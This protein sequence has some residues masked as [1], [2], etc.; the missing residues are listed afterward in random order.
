MA[1]SAACSMASVSRALRP[2]PRAA[3]CSAARLGTRLPR[4]YLFLIFVR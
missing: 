3:V 1:P 2:R 4:S